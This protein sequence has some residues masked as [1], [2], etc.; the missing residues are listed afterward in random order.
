[1]TANGTPSIPMSKPPGPA[2]LV[3][4]HAMPSG[5]PEDIWAE[6]RAK[7]AESGSIDLSEIL[8]TVED[9]APD[10]LESLRAALTVVGVEVHDDT[11][12]AEAAAA[13]AGAALETSELE[14]VLEGAATTA[15]APEPARTEDEPESSDHR[16]NLDEGATGSSE[17]PVRIY[18]QEIG[19][20]P[21]L[22]MDDERSLSQRMERGEDAERRLLT[23]RFFLSENETVELERV[24][25]DGKRAKKNLVEANLRLVVSIAKRYTGRG[26]QLLDLIQ[27]GNLGLIR[28]VEKFDW[29][30]GVKFSTYATWWIR[31]AITRALA[32]QARTIRIPVHMVDTINRLLRS[33]RELVQKLNREPTA[34]EIAR[35]LE[36][37]PER[38]REIQRVSQEPISLDVPVGEEEDSSL[39]EFIEDG[40]AV[41]PEEAAARR[42]LQQQ[43]DEA[44]DGLS[45][46][47]QQVLKYRFGLDTG[48]PR[49]LEEVGQA[50]GVTRERIR[51]IEAKSLSK[52]RH[53]KA[54]N[55]LK[56][57]IED[58]GD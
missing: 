9:F 7:A 4:A 54:N 18:L 43:I 21:L 12:L 57:Y 23:E 42:M 17:D 2:D 53:P 26:M 32:D 47:E 27:E 48:Q 40:Q 22:T 50:L 3:H 51:Q 14:A 46:R 6:L 31:Q 44:L 45:E 39:A 34:E 58:G 16:P 28:A 55:R 35:E 41:M 29:R 11:D 8:E 56:D 52:L 13:D 10:Q 49:T 25:A 19:R 38:V 33:Q 37:E 24:V 5:V 20:V 36:M 1:M 15:P 30:K